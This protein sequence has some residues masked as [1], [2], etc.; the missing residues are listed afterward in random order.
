MKTLKAAFVIAIL[1]MA[2][3]ITNAQTKVTHYCI[4][5]IA[6]TPQSQGMHPLTY[7]TS[8]TFEVPATD[9]RYGVKVDETTKRIIR[10]QYFNYLL[11]NYPDAIK[12]FKGGFSESSIKVFTQPT[13]SKVE[14]MASNWQK[15]TEKYNHI[16]VENF[17][18]KDVDVLKE[19]QQ[20]IMNR[21]KEYLTEGK[22]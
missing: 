16:P 5:T 19:D 10:W 6:N 4:V 15:G 7:V 2:T 11:K 1:L 13:Q 22:D 21:F 9:G 8:N 17:E 12:V 20:K 14:E 3:N 18:Y